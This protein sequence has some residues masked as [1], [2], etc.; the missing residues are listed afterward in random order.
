MEKNMTGLRSARIQIKALS[1][2]L[3]T[4]A[5]ATMLLMQLPTSAGKLPCS[6][7]MHDR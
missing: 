6:V 5:L 4:P 3:Q 1:S 2:G 7:Y